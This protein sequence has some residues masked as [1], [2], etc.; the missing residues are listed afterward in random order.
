MVLAM[1]CRH[2]LGRSAR[3]AFFLMSS[4]LVGSAVVLAAFMAGM[5]NTVA[6]EAMKCNYGKL[7]FVGVAF[8]VYSVCG[9]IAT[10]STIENKW[11]RAI[12]VLLL[13]VGATAA[14]VFAFAPPAVTA[15]FVL[16]W[17]AVFAYTFFYALCILRGAAE[18]KMLIILSVS[19]AAGWVLVAITVPHALASGRAAAFIDLSFLPD[20]YASTRDAVSALAL[21]AWMATP[22][23][24]TG[25][26]SFALDIRFNATQ[27]DWSVLPRD[28]VAPPL[29][30]LKLLTERGIVGTAMMA[31][32]LLLMLVTYFAKLVGW[33]FVGTVPR[34]G[35]WVAPV[36]LAAVVANAF[37]DC[38]YLR[39]DVL[40]P[41]AAALAL[42]AAEFPKAGKG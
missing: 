17:L 27:A 13:S 33:L 7:S 39:V 16:A 5:G 3:H 34:P 26:G 21:K 29:G 14:G 41:V 4:A 30:W 28:L 42:S 2:A 32:P 38:S 40:M 31:L 25:V 22:W 19:L 37:F 36:V 11:N 24:G 12:P 6:A 35:C 20:W 23:T 8:A 10:V 9:V 1:A 15:I 18:F